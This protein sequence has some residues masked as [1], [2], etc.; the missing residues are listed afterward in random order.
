M[1]NNGTAI[2][3]F[4]V[5]EAKADQ[6]KVPDTGDVSKMPLWIAL[7]TMSAFGMAAATIYTGKK[8]V[9]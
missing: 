8:I 3:T 6:D 9:K 4:T 5:E 2:A 1:S 7:L